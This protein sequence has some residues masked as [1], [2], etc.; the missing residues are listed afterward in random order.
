MAEVTLNTSTVIM[1][2]IADF[3]NAGSKSLREMAVQAGPFL[4]TWYDQEHYVTA[5]I[6]VV[7]FIDATGIVEIAIKY[8]KYRASKYKNTFIHNYK[9]KYQDK[10]G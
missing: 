4:T 3:V 6:L 9:L 1:D 5:N 8:N 7:D 10:W 2:A